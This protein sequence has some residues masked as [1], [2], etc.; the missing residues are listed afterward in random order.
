MVQM[1]LYSLSYTSPKIRSEFLAT[2]PKLRTTSPDNESSITHKE[3]SRSKWNIT[4]PLSSIAISDKAASEVL[5]L[6]LYPNSSKEVNRLVIVT[7]A[8]VYL[9]NQRTRCFELGISLS[10]MFASNWYY[11]ISAKSFSSKYGM[12]IALQ[13]LNNRSILASLDSNEFSNWKNEI[14]NITSSE[15]NQSMMLSFLATLNSKLNCRYPIDVEPSFSCLATEELEAEETPIFSVSYSPSGDRVAVAQG[16]GLCSILRLVHQSNCGVRWKEETVL[17]GHGGIVSNADWSLDGRFVLTTSADRTARIWSTSGGI[18]RLTVSSNRSASANGHGQTITSIAKERSSNISSDFADHV[19]FG[20]FHL[21]DN[22]FHLTCRNEIFFFS[23]KIDT[24]ANALQKCHTVASYKRVAKF[25]FDNCTRLTTVCSTNLFYSYLI[26]AAGSDRSLY[27]LDINTKNIVRNIPAIHDATVTGIAINQ[28]SIY[29]SFTGESSLKSGFSDGG[30]NTPLGSYSLFATAAPGD[31]VRLW[32]LRVAKG[33]I[34]ELV[35]CRISSGGVT[36]REGGIGGSVRDAAVPPVTLTFSPCGRYV[37]FGAL[38]A[39]ANNTVNYLTPAVVDI[40]RV[41]SPLTLLNPPDRRICASSAATVVTWCPARPED[42]ACIENLSFQCGGSDCRS[43]SSSHSFTLLKPP[44]LLFP[45]LWV[46]YTGPTNSLTESCKANEPEDCETSEIVNCDCVVC[47]DKSSGKH[48]GQFTCEGCKSFFKRSVRRQLTYTCRAVRQCSVDLHH[49]N[50]CQYCRFQ[51]CL[52]MGMRKEAVQ[53]GR[54]S[55]SIMHPY[56]RMF[57]R[58][59]G[60]DFRLSSVQSYQLRSALNLLTAVLNA[61]QAFEVTYSN[62]TLLVNNY[63]N[64]ARHFPY[65]NRIQ[66]VD[67]LVLLN[68]AWSDVTML[69]LAQRMNY[70]KDLLQSSELQG[71]N[72]QE[73]ANMVR[74]YDGINQIICLNL[75]FVEYSCLKGMILFGSGGL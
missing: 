51:K 36:N 45:H 47:G 31:S 37:C 23:Y 4:K 25:N 57:D 41:C 48:Y 21:E 29:A 17:A 19:Q 10:D 61:E 59:E 22:F 11:A 69:T 54:L 1:M 9:L 6:G 63:V 38:S 39:C 20:R 14:C 50:Q 60:S 12:L 26:L 42:A 71:G 65:F 7:S 5:A 28:G 74:I 16:N 35:R 70:G 58:C 33:H 8:A 27:V 64:W 24:N 46:N 55:S 67:Q 68:D 30:G 52:R 40:R 56:F 53:Q 49:R 73:K 44:N 72:Y 62:S 75:S 15:G 34:A 13:S 2:V 18:L 3:S 32:D 66:K 43:T